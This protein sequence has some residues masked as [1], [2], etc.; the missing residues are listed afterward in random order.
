MHELEWQ[1]LPQNKVY[2]YKSIQVVEAHLQLVRSR[3]NLPDELDHWSQ[4]NTSQ[5]KMLHLQWLHLLHCNATYLI[6]ISQCT[7]CIFCT[8]QKRLI[9]CWKRGMCKSHLVPA[10]SQIMT[11]N[12][13][14]QCRYLIQIL[15]HFNAFVGQWSSS[16][17]LVISF[18]PR[19]R[20]A[21]SKSL[22]SFA[23]HSILHL[24][25]QMEQ[26]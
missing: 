4:I 19:R 20:C 22:Y 18:S 8:L 25:W 1:R 3:S 24:D 13:A 16:A 5:M 15:D 21:S 2:S 14:Q 23:C 9:I 26:H 6:D 10:D 11:G 12:N 7:W 17:C